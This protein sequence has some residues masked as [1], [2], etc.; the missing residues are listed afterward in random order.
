MA[1]AFG[2][3]GVAVAAWA[4]FGFSGAKPVHSGFDPRLGWAAAAVAGQAAVDAPHVPNP[5]AMS[6]QAPAPS[7]APPAT[8]AP[9]LP[10]VTAAAP[11]TPAPAPRTAPPATAAPA[12]PAAPAEV[13]LVAQE[14][15]AAV[16]QQSGGAYVI[17]SG[18]G[19]VALLTQWM[20][21]EGGL[22]ADNPLNTSLDSSSYP[23]EFTVAGVDTGIPIF[24]SMHAGVVATATTLLQN[25]AYAKILSL[26]QNGNASCQAFASAVIRSP[27]AASHYGH[28]PAGF[29]GASP[30]RAVVPG[31]RGHRVGGGHHHRNPLPRPKAGRNKR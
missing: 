6:G 3:V 10:R 27:W 22:W 2:G 13:A 24:P 20:A 5:A 31:N 4:I 12:A 29:C 21:N 19:N 26:L 25:P 23:H 16:D 7:A 8:A 17:P 28:D 9:T 30:S 11:V 1:V 18:P 14:I 15:I